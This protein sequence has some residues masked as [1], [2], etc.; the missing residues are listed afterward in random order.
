MIDFLP[1]A[2]ELFPFTQNMR[3]DLHMHP[4]LGFREIRTGGIVAK[5]L[6]SLGIEV[7]K[8]MGKTGVVGL[9]EGAK[10]GPTLLLR[11]DMDALPITEE[12]GAGYASQ[13]QGVMH[14][15]G[16][17]GHTAI[18][19]TVARMLHAHRDE[20]AGTIKFCFQPSEEGTYGEE[21]GGAEMMMRDGVLDS[22]KVDMSLSLHLW[23]EKPLGWLGI[24]SGPVMAGAEIFTVRITGKG[25]HGAIP[26][27]TID[28][29]VAAAQIV[30]AL[31]TIVA[32][33]VAPLETA[34]VS[35]TT[36]QAGTAFNVIPQTAELTG[37]IRT[38]DAS[39]RQKVVQR[40]EQIA[41]GVG[42]ALGCQVDAE[43]KRM[44][45]AL[46]NDD[47]ISSTVQA[48][49]RRVLSKSDLDTAGYITM[50]A[51]DMAFMQ[52]KVP[53]CYFFVGS[54]DKA[55]HLD[56][57]HHHPK[58]DFNEEALIRAS[59]LMASAAMDVLSSR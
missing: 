12:T 24:A 37:T 57:G 48:T 32:R 46:I 36:I 59:A 29:V 2:E 41:R 19:L 3:R 26:Q 8:G 50:G 58:F 51:E 40:F 18:G 53:G 42:E 28:P 30:G 15:C 14:A 33:N 17:D 9:M 39:V 7:T 43:V 52:E 6:E 5:E 45:P 38:F 56:Y 23:N 25:G 49:A 22:P 20:L 44:T 21:V 16:H 4:E 1:Q 34:V 55:R 11:F 27:Q 47:A 13:N 35:V 10:P 54:N 31:Q